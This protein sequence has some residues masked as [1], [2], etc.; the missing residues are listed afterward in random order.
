MRRPVLLSERSSIVIVQQSI[1][2]FSRTTWKRSARISSLFFV[3]FLIVLLAFYFRAYVPSF[4]E[5]PFEERTNCTI[6]MIRSNSY[7]CKNSANA[8]MCQ[9]IIGYCSD[10]RNRSLFSGW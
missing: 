10:G 8:A 5:E 3:I 7:M 9:L 6:V 4:K 1:L 2:S